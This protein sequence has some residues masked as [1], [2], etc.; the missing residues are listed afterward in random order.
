M[1]FGKYKVNIVARKRLKQK[2]LKKNILI[3]CEGSTEVCYFDMLNKK[4]RATRH[5]DVR[6]I[7]TQG[8]QGEAMVKYL[9][10]QL[11]MNPNY[12]HKQY[13]SIFAI[14]DKDNL[15]DKNIIDAHKLAQQNDIKIIFSNE[16]FDLWLLKHYKR[17]SGHTNRQSIYKQLTQTLNLTDSYEKYKADNEFINKNFFDYVH[18]AFNN[19]EHLTDVEIQTEIPP[20]PYTNIHYYLETIYE[21]NK[22][23]SGW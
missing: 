15:P 8:K 3:F 20:N 23:S 13:D 4:Y 18:R 1:Y 14:F 21:R 2:T 22:T 16:C 7:D 9:L 6:A 12:K 17:I 5:V 11:K 10:H 19:A